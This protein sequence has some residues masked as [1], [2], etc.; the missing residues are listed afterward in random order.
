MT[1]GALGLLPKTNN[2]GGLTAAAAKLSPGQISAAIRP[3]TG[4]GYYYIKVIE[5]NDTQVNYEYIQ[6][7]LTAFADQLRSIEE[8]D[9]T[10]H[11]IDLPEVQMTNPQQQQQ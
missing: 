7:P 9:R 4:D 8:S 1:Y 2:D 11:Y 10:K 5:V 6:V 3:A